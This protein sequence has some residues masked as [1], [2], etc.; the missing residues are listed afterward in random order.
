MTMRVD[1]TATTNYMSRLFA[2]DAITT[3]RPL[4]MGKTYIEWATDVWNPIR[5]CTKV[6]RGCDNCYAMRQAHRFSGK[7]QPYEGL[8]R[9]ING[10]P[11]WIG[12]AR[13]VPKVLDQPLRW[14]KPRRIFVNSMSDLFHEDVPFEFVAQVF[15]TMW[16]APQHIFQ[17]L[18]KR[19]ERMREFIEINNDAQSW[20][21][22][23]VWLGVSVEN[24]VTADVRIPLLLQTPA[25]VRWISAEPLLGEIDL[26][27][28]DT[29][30]QYWLDALD[31]DVRIAHDGG[32]PNGPIY[33]K[34]DW[35][36]AGAESGP[37]AR[38]ADIDWFQ[39]LRNQCANAN[40]PFFLKQF[41][42]NGK[43]IPI[44]ELDD[45]TWEEYPA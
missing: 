24:Q 16:N 11:Q 10:R 39:L 30:D 38:S 41:A 32:M 34:L 3:E 29:G 8:T 2:R 33:N 15:W 18:T 28:I 45:R 25:A 31:G 20:P 22:P 35:V 43:K 17:I 9:T 19:P 36:V 4:V 37:R 7:G 1:M 44:P 26:T 13:C 23:N 27:E 40:V 21:L 14:R 6:S 12:K 42:V 5:G